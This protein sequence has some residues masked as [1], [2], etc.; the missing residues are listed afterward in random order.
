MDPAGPM[1]G[2]ALSVR[3]VFIAPLLVKQSDN[4]D[5]TDYCLHY[6]NMNRLPRV[7]LLHFKNKA[8]CGDGK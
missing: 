4:M 1:V 3:H 5:S 6:E 2:E 7:T 8:S